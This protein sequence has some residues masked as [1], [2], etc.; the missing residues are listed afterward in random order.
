MCYDVF[1][2]VML[3]SWTGGRPAGSTI[4]LTVAVITTVAPDVLMEVF[5][6]EL[7]AICSESGA[8]TRAGFYPQDKRNN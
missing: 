8:S 7:T 1:T 2:M 5:G 3:L 4:T 6:G